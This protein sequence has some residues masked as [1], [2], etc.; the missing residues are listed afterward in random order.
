MSQVDDP[1]EECSE[2]RED[3]S[4]EG[5]AE[6]SADERPITEPVPSRREPPDESRPTRAARSPATPVGAGNNPTGQ[7]SY[8]AACSP[9]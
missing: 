3:G 1:T 6:G 9:W 7:F 4:S 5:G 2:G 8:C